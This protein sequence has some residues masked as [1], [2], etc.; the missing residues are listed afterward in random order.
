MNKNH[1]CQEDDDLSGINWNPPESDGLWI[2]WTAL[3]VAVV[4][5][6]LLLVLVKG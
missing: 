3:I 2:V 4:V 5:G 6:V 1:G